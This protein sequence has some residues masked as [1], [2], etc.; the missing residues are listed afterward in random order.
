MIN[1]VLVAT[2]VHS[3]LNH[4]RFVMTPKLCAHSKL[5]TNSCGTYKPY[6]N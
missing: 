5:F 4:F 2:F 6:L 3:E 1:L